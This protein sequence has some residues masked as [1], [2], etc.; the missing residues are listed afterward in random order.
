MKIGIIFFKTASELIDLCNKLAQGLSIIPVKAINKNVYKFLSIIFRSNEIAISA[1][2][3][4][5]I[6]VLSRSTGVN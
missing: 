6:E 3:P 2:L 1:I 4:I 5:I